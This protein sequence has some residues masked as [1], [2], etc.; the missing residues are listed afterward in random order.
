V[1]VAVTVNRARYITTGNTVH[2]LAELTLTSA[3]TVGSNIVIGG[4]PAAIQPTGLIFQSLSTLGICCVFDN[5]S[6]VYYGFL[7]AQSASDWRMRDSNTR[8]VIGNNP[9][10]ALANTDIITFRGTYERA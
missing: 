8:G 6:A 5:G 2:I 7:V 3:G 1:A 9:N 4:I 10:F